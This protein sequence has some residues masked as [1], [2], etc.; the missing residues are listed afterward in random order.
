MKKNKQDLI[1][2]ANI[3]AEDHTF[4][5]GVIEKLLGDLDT[6]DKFS[7]EH[8]IGM[9]TVQELLKEM[10]EIELNHEQLRKQIKE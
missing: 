4:K 9:S 3:L 2:E 1:K 10:E 6:K 5:K 8:L 7:E